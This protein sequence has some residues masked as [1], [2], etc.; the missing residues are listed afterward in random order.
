MSGNMSRSWRLYVG[1]DGYIVDHGGYI[2]IMV[3]RYNRVG[4]GD[5][6]VSN[7]LGLGLYG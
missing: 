5:T 3:G 1:H 2:R 7:D 4:S 6:C